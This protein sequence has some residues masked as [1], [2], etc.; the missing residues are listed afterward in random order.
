M[1]DPLSRLAILYGTDKFGLHD[2]TPNYHRLLRH[3]RKEPI[4]MLEIGVGGYADPKAGGSSLEVWRDYFPHGRIIGI[5]IAAKSLDLGPRVNLAQGS[6]VD[7][8]FLE[9]LVTQHGPFDIILDDGSHRNEHV[10]ESYRLLFQAVKPGGFYIVEDVQ[11]AVFPRFGGSLELTA[12]NTIGLFSDLMAAVVSGAREAAEIQTLF[13][14]HNIVGVRKTGGVVLPPEVDPV[15]VL[16]AYAADAAISEALAPLEDGAR[17]AVEGPVSET[18]RR[19]FLEVDHREIAVNFPAT[20]ISDQARTVFALYAERGQVL[21]EKGQNNY[22]SN[23]DFDAENPQAR[24]ALDAFKQVLWETPTESGLQVYGTI[25]ER[26]GWSETCLEIAARLKTLSVTNSGSYQFLART[27]K[28]NGQLAELQMILEAAIAKFPD[29]PGFAGQF[30]MHLVSQGHV[31]QAEDVIYKARDAG[32]DSADL[33]MRM[34][35]IQMRL[36]HLDTALAEAQDATAKKPKMTAGWITLARVHA[37]RKDWEAVEKACVTG[38][39]KTTNQ[40]AA[41]LELLSQA[42][43]ALEDA[44]GARAAIEQGLRAAPNHPRLLRLRSALDAG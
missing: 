39:S 5:D 16:P 3:L 19:R 14:F 43:L 6:Q 18:L 12:P 33:S 35:L 20:D 21:L 2:Y 22:P 1:I 34:A 8:A 26:A 24:A 11:T 27:A 30:A 37:T 44:D 15:K 10:V 17:I 13:R 4:A 28:K 36:G 41:L 23:F 32:A 25:A 40:Q 9:D 29:D 38:I 7:P 31:E 42:R